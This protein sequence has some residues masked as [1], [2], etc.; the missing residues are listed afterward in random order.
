MW[1]SRRPCDQANPEL[2]VARAGKP[3]RARILALPMS[4]GL[5]I[6]KQPDWCSS[7]KRCRRSAGEVMVEDTERTERGNDGTMEGSVLPSFLPSV[8]RGYS[9]CCSAP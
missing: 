8:N 3:S 2:V 9:D 5:G 1:L 6:T 7:R 4:H